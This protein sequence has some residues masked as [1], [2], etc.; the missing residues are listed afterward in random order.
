MRI[1]PLAD[2]RQ[3]IAEIAAL[4][5][6]E[7]GDLAPWASRDEIERRFAGQAST[8]HAPF[9]LVALADSGE[10]LGTASV[11]LFELP[12][13]PDKAHWMG[14]VFIPRA[15]RG[16]GIGSALVLACITQSRA[17]DLPALYLYTP[18]Q[19]ALY[20]RF[21]WQEIAREV[22]NDEL[23]SIMVLALTETVPDDAACRGQEPEELD[24]EGVTS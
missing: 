10:L 1:E 17:L 24:M 16:R 2:H 5:H 11:K 18:D 4:L 12:S 19:Q 23:V 22:V 7:W 14:E 21:G 20:E 8:G 9:T 3:L 6:A 15:L 13:H